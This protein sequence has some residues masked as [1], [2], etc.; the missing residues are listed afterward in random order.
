MND[1]DDVGG[2]GGGEANQ[3]TNQVIH[4]E[5]NG[6]IGS[7]AVHCGLRRINCSAP[8]MH[9]PRRTRTRIK[10]HRLGSCF[11]IYVVMKMMVMM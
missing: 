6:I 7:I 10:V 1:N 3:P 2:G 11:V 4:G 5:Y 9:S 8:L